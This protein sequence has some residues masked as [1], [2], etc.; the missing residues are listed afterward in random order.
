MLL[1]V[2]LL[3]RW[4][5]HSLAGSLAISLCLPVCL[6]H[7]VGLS[8]WVSQSSDSLCVSLY[9]LSWFRSGGRAPDWP[10]VLCIDRSWY[11]HGHSHGTLA[12]SC[13]LYS[14]CLCSCCLCSHSCT[15]TASAPAAS[16]L[17]PVLLLP[18][19]LLS[20]LSLLCSCCLYSCCLCSHSCA[21]MLTACCSASRWASLAFPLQWDSR[22]L[23]RHALALPSG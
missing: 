23:W 18:V 22:R 8:M 17:T 11:H 7:C 9:V 10:V 15:L 2:N 16:A 3:C 5:Y 13:C 12:A 6:N 21:Q 1:L 14:H 4:P 19:L 20:V